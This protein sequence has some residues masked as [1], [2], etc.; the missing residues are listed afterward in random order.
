VIDRGS[1]PSGTN[2]TRASMLIMNDSFSR[3]ASIGRPVHIGV[4]M[5]AAYAAAEDGS[6]PRP[7][8]RRCGR[9]ASGRPSGPGAAPKSTIV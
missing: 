3:A 4:G 5:F 8:V 7:S 9:S 6:K 1:V 2:A